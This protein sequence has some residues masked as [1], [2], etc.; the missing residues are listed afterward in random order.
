MVME[1]RWFAMS[2][3]SMLLLLLLSLLWLLRVTSVDDIVGR[4]VPDWSL[5]MRPSSGRAWILGVAVVP[6]LEQE[7][8]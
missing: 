8:S 2:M 4:L 5:R 6:L 3:I 1:P 7:V